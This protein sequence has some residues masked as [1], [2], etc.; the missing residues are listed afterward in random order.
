MERYWNG[1]GT[2]KEQNIVLSGRN[3][4]PETLRYIIYVREIVSTKVAITK[5]TLV[6]I[7]EIV[8]GQ[9]LVKGNVWR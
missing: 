1:F 8:S 5:E 2:K 7:R 9:D 4:C 3:K 6:T